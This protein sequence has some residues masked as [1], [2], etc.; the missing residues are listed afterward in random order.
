MVPFSKGFGTVTVTS[1]IGGNHRKVLRKRGCHQMPHRMGLRITMQQQHRR[2][3][4]PVDQG[5]LGF[6][7][8]RSFLLE[9]LEQDPTPYYLL[10]F[11]Q[12]KKVSTTL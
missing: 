12:P 2:P 9:P 3:I 6:G 8:L 5:Y 11:L 7:S 10:P 4:T 1:Q